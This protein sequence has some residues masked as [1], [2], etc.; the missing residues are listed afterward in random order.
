MPKLVCRKCEI[1]LK[2]EENGVVI[3]EL[4]QKNKRVYKIWSADLWECR[5]C[6]NEVVAGFS[7]Q[8]SFHEGEKS[9]GEIRAVIKI[10]ELQGKTII[11]DKEVI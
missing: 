4:C 1:E 11:Y 3:V 10:H 2:P 9:E 5:N 6:G 8:P 7:S